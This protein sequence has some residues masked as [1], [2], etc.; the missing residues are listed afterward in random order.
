MLQ[1]SIPPKKLEVKN[2]CKQQSK[3]TNCEFPS[4]YVYNFLSGFFWNCF[5]ILI[6]SLNYGFFMPSIEFVR[7]FADL[8]TTVWFEAKYPET[9][10]TQEENAFYKRVL[11]L[12]FARS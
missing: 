12:T 2:F 6:N 10:S 9:G 4:F 3:W 1:T 7:Q 5:S 8:L 11:N